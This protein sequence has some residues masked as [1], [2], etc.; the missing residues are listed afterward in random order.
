[1]HAENIQL[2]LR[3]SKTALSCQQILNIYHRCYF[4][5]SIVVIRKISR[6]T[7]H[8]Q[9]KCDTQN[10]IIF[11]VWRYSKLTSFPYSTSALIESSGF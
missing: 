2:L 7:A 11:Q 4:T 9:T 6:Q 3:I 5:S 10:H 1:M 8:W